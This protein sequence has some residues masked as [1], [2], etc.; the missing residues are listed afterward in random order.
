MTRK[1]AV[2]RLSRR[3]RETKRRAAQPARKVTRSRV[4]SREAVATFLD[5]VAQHVEHIA[6]GRAPDKIT[7]QYTGIYKRIADAFN[8]LIDVMHMRAADIEALTTAALEGRLDFRADT[9]K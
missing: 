2:Q 3:S 9:A 8:T 1:S 5:R 6:E 7:T 4:E